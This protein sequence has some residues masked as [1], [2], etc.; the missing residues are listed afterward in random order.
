MFP[1]GKPPPDRAPRPEQDCA[2]APA[3]VARPQSTTAVALNAG[4]RVA[5]VDP[6]EAL[7]ALERAIEQAV[8]AESGFD[9]KRVEALR[10]AI[11]EGRYQPDPEQVA[12]RLL[13]LE[14][15]LHPGP[16]E[17]SP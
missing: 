4:E 12:R 9:V 14:R 17:P 5:V 1:E 8:A 16:D 13:D 6:N 7:Q 10:R 2:R 15:A 11:A 3:P